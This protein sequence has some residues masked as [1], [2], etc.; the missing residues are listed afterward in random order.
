MFLYDKPVNTFDDLRD[1]ADAM[2]GHFKESP[3]DKL[4]LYGYPTHIVYP[5]M[6]K[7]ADGSIRWYDPVEPIRLG[8]EFHERR[9]IKRMKNE[10]GGQT[11]GLLE[12]E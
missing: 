5:Q 6:I 11:M 7:E 1:L 9:R 10:S 8:R 4:R 12:G 2:D 3:F